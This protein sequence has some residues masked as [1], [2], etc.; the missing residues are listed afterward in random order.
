[1]ARSP[2]TQL[3]AFLKPHLCFDKKTYADFQKRISD[4]SFTRDEN[5]ISHFCTFFLPYCQKTKKVFLIH[6][7]KSDLWISPGG[8]IDKGE[9]LSNY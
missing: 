3:K 9:P 6:H 5:P 8:H 1:M 7:R 2:S 4:G